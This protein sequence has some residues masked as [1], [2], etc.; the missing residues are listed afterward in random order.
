MRPGHVL[1]LSCQRGMGVEAH[2]AIHGREVE[3]GI[4]AVFATL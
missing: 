4:L 1:V 2:Y 3:W